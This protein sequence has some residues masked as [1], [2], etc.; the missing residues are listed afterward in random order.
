MSKNSWGGSR[1]GAGR[2]PIS[3]E[4]KK[5]GVKIYITEELKDEI[6]KYGC[7]KNFSDKTVN[8]LISGLISKKDCKED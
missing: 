8:L 7:G 2:N 3:P 6:I 1:K 5:Q 4:K